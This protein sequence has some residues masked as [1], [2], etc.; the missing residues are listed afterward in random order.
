VEHR[1]T[2]STLTFFV[3]SALMLVFVLIAYA[4]LRRCED[5][6]KA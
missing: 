1:E 5:K 6:R 4:V 3:T 2:T